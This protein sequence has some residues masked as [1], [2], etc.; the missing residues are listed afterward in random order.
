[1]SA[2][3]IEPDVGRIR[4]LNDAFR[5][6]FVGGVV[7]V[8]PGVEALDAD[9]KRDLLAGVREFDRFEAANDPFEEHE[10][11]ELTVA[12]TSFFWKIDCYDRKCRRGSVDPTD[13]SV[14]T[15]VLTILRADEY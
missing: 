7:C 9:T 10:F 1:M 3:E 11:G 6:T 12:G 5:T 15:R 13:P 8:A 4:A 2:V 14:T